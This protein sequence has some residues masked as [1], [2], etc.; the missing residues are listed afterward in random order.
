MTSAG[1][2]A[3]VVRQVGRLL[4]LATGLL[5]L[6]VDWRLT[7]VA[8]V[9]LAVV[10]LGTWW[11]RRSPG[12]WRYGLQL[13]M[14]PGTGMRAWL[15]RLASAVRPVTPDDRYAWNSR[16]D[17]VPLVVPVRLANRRNDWPYWAFNIRIIRSGLE[18]RSTPEGPVLSVTL[19]KDD[20]AVYNNK[21][22]R[23]L[24]DNP[25]DGRPYD[26]SGLEEAFDA[27]V[28][29]AES[30]RDHWRTQVGVGFP[31]RWASGG[32]LPIV[33][34]GGTQWAACFFRD[35]K[36]KGWNLA[37]GG[38]E[39][40]REQELVRRVLR[41]EFR[42]ELLVVDQD[43]LGRSGRQPRAVGVRALLWAGESPRGLPTSEGLGLRRTH[44][45]LTLLEHPGAH[46]GQVI[47]VTPVPTPWRVRVVSTD[48]RVEWLD[49]VL[50]SIDAM[51]LGVE[52]IQVV[53]L[54]LGTDDVLLD[55]EVL[56]K[57]P[58][59]AR[60]PVVLL[61]LGS[62][63]DRFHTTG[64]LG[65]LGPSGEKDLGVLDPHEYRSFPQDAV[66]TRNRIA[67]LR[68]RLSESLP[69][70]ELTAIRAELQHLEFML[71]RHDRLASSGTGHS[72]E[73]A[74]LGPVT[75]K[76]LEALFRNEQGPA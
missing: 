41:R 56:E 9:I 69:Q 15:S 55:G 51:E 10:G 50:P 13:R 39:S 8:A 35:I 71:P 57:V 43:P 34:R 73:L 24:K 40:I 75:W 7:L 26:W 22:K 1:A 58:A 63:R 68:G 52:A 29:E 65:T 67:V 16:H 28:L 42:E 33:T 32:C 49:H 48:S 17:G 45:R 62:L 14:Q 59:L 66:L 20:W 4:L 31:L 38:S 37:N 27:A 61:H 12:L 53:H 54:R 5:T 23:W 36:P 2:R 60:R 11:V 47:E 6:F 76:T 3:T 70:E 18:I 21:G 30:R 72:G 44:D 46:D 19:G 64:G 74:R 25:P